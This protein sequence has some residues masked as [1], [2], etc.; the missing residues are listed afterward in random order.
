MA[1]FLQAGFNLFGLLKVTQYHEV[2]F[3]A[4]DIPGL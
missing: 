1:A 4:N 3:S 2:K